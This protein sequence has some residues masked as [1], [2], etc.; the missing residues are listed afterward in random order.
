MAK[1][2]FML[3]HPMSSSAGSNSLVLLAKAALELHHEVYIV[4]AADG[5]YQCMR[6]KRSRSG[7][8]K[9]MRAE[10]QALKNAGAEMVVSFG[11]MSY[12]GVDMHADVHPAVKVVTFEEIA[13]IMGEVDKVVC[14]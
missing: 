8:C 1:L 2:G 3:T 12:R 9:D 11:C 4:F 10:L 13:R 7:E 5:V 6:D 14:L